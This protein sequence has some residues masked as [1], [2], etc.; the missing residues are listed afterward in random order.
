MNR[1]ALLIGLGGAALVRVPAWADNSSK[2]SGIGVLSPAPTPFLDLLFEAL[3]E[4]GWRVGRNLLIDVRYTQGDPQ[5]TESLARELLQRGVSVIVTNFTATAMAAHR[6]TRETP[7]VMLTSGF[8]VEGGLA[9]SLARPGGNVTG[10]AMYASGGAIF[11]KYVEL[12]REMVT[13]LRE[14]GVFWGY[15]PPLYKPE[16]VAPATE[17]LR[18]AA[19][20]LNIKLRFWQTGTQADLAS[21]LAA[22]SSLSLDALFV[23]AGVV[24]ALPEVAA[25]I[26]RF[27]LQ[28]QLPT[29][30]DGAGPFFAAGGVLAYSPNAKEAASR[31]A[32]FIDRILKGARPADLPIEQPTKYELVLNSRMAKSLGV[33]I[34]PSLMLR[35]DRVVDA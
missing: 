9:D 32:Y 27:A 30:T 12:L 3:P 19:D 18:R 34:P 15:A 4:R 21:A 23:T 25:T 14:L 2:V 11:G 1:R 24:H 6:V 28:R 33:T 5:R 31:V 7:I 16:Q 8:P 17:G 26:S 29:L 20:A 10:M 35:V 22:A 13:S